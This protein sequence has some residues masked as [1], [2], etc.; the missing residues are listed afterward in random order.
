[1]KSR[2]PESNDHFTPYSR[3]FHSG[4]NFGTRSGGGLA[5]APDVRLS[6]DAFEVART[7]MARVADEDSKRSAS[8]CNA[9]G[10][11]A[12]ATSMPPSSHAAGSYAQTRTQYKGSLVIKL[13]GRTWS[14]V[15]QYISVENVNSHSSHVRRSSRPRAAQSARLPFRHDTLTFLTRRRTVA[16]EARRR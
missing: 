10:T 9:P 5:V 13:L 11:R 4:V 16:Y 7:G 8:S 12:A 3:Y 15:I 14:V 6:P 1:M 2:T